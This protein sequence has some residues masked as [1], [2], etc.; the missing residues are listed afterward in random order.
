MKLDP[1]HPELS[2]VSPLGSSPPSDQGAPSGL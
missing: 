1:F 2:L